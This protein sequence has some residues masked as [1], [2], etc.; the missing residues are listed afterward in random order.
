MLSFFGVRE[1]LIYDSDV[2]VLAGGLTG[3]WRPNYLRARG[4]CTLE[5]PKKKKKIAAS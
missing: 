3:V 1:A 4:H 2:H 5:L